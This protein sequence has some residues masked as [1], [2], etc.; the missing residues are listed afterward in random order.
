[1]AQ[2]TLGDIL[3]GAAGSMPNR[4]LLNYQMMQAQGVNSLR[5]AQT[6]DALAN[7]HNAQLEAQF[8]ENA[9]T[10]RA[11]LSDQIT[12]VVGD[13]KLGDLLAG[14][15]QAG[16]EKSEPFNQLTE[17]MA[18]IQNAMRRNEVAN[19]STSPQ[20]RSLDV[21]A[22]TGKAPEL[23]QPVPQEYTAVPGL[24]APTPQTTAVGGAVTAEHVAKAEQEHAMAK[25]MS[26]GAGGGLT[27]Q[28][29][30]DAA[31]VVMA[32]PTKIGQYAGFGQMGQSVK[33]AIN[34]RIAQQLTDAGMQ[35]EDMIRQRAIAHASVGS[36]TQ[37]AKQIQ[38]L[39]AFT[40][41]VKANGDRILQILSQIGADGANVPVLAG[42][43][44]ALG[45]NLGDPELAELRSVFGTYQNEVARLVAA[46]PSMNGVL[47]DKARGDVQAMAPDNMTA[48]QA[49]QVINRIATEIAIRR[50]GVQSSMDSATGAQLPVVSRETARETAPAQ[51]APAQP[52]GGG[53]AAGAS[54]APAAAPIPLDQYLKSKGY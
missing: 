48:A 7:A 27:P 44:R 29:L 11:Q 10:S 51:T 43:Q 16:G 13:R 14:Y 38:T 26:G 30:E 50:Q 41:L 22:N 36:A 42:L 17:G 34:N 8:R 53:P 33:L 28:A 31:R 4:P 1:M 24:P 39:D 9:L 23:A 40:P 21:L 12:A 19:V 20:Q 5:S 15:V 32:D 3:A 45:R 54:A 6:E 52:P 2:Y 37:A 47:S 35:P 25:M 49:R 46:G 18:N